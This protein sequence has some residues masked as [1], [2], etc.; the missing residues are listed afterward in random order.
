MQAEDAI[1]IR[2][3]KNKIPSEELV[4]GDVLLWQKE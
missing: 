1:V 2:E 3:G 4:P